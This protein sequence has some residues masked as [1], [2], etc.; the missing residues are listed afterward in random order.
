MTSADAGVSK[1]PTYS[2]ELVMTAPSAAST[3]SVSVISAGGSSFINCGGKHK[4]LN[5]TDSHHHK[6]LSK[7]RQ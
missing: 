2:D 7:T 5:L 1:S 4:H 6:L 3:S